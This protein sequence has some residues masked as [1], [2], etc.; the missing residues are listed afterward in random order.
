MV[1]MDEAFLLTYFWPTNTWLSPEGLMLKKENRN[2]VFVQLDVRDKI[3][4]LFYWPHLELNR[5]LP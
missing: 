2:D 1:E 5:N 4:P 3:W